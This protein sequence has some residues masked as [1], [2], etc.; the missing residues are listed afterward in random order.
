VIETES[1]M[2]AFVRAR[3]DEIEAHAPLLSAGKHTGLI[4][5][6]WV[7]REIQAKRRVLD[8][9]EHNLALGHD[10]R[11][12]NMMHSLKM[13]IYAMADVFQGHPDYDRDMWGE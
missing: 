12:S 6:T 9:Y 3:L 13:A 5:Q 11:R 7:E 4:T 2:V 1:R 8:H 10:P